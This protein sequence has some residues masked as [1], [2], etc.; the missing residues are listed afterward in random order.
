VAHEQDR[1]RSTRTSHIH[2]VTKP[3]SRKSSARTKR[4]TANTKLCAE[5]KAPAVRDS[6]R[7][8]LE[9]SSDN[10][11]TYRNR[12]AVAG[13][14]T[15]VRSQTRRQ[16]QISRTALE[17]APCVERRTGALATETTGY[18]TGP[19]GSK[20]QDQTE[21]EERGCC[22]VRLPPL[23]AC[24]PN[25]AQ[26]VT[27]RRVALEHELTGSWIPPTEGLNR[28]IGRDLDSRAGNH[29]DEAHS[30]VSNGTPAANPKQEM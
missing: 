7:T 5:K 13:A 22:G 20:N 14:R 29:T 2:K 23:R 24:P 3:S 6:L 18:E 25:R 1:L 27:E 16:K 21:T 11:T 26:A 10:R 30:A 19:S 9:R 17:R 12:E 8:K 4:K 15:G 28:K